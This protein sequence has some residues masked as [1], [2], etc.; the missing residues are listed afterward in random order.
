M[1]TY[2]V[3]YFKILNIYCVITIDQFIGSCIRFTRI[4]TFDKVNLH[5]FLN[6]DF[7]LAQFYDYDIFLLF[8]SFYF[9]NLKCSIQ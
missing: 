3:F 4:K 6:V 1:T 9:T 7:K 8:V 2:K 5:S